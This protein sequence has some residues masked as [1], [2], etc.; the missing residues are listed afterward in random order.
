MR[1]KLKATILSLTLLTFSFILSGCV[2]EPEITP[3]YRLSSVIRVVNVSNNLNNIRVTIADQTPV[4]SLNAMPIG[5]STEYFDILS[6]KKIFR[7]YDESGQMLFSREIELASLELMTIIFA[8]HY[9]QNADLTTFT[10]FEL[11]EG[12][13]YVS[14]A[15]EAGTALFNFVHA[16]APVDSFNSRKYRV[17]ANYTPDGATARDTTYNLPPRDFLE[18]GQT[19]T[20]VATPAVYSFR[21]IPENGT[22]VTYNPVEIKENHLYYMFIYGNPNNVQVFVDEVVPPPIRPRD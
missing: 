2:E 19:L 7:V 15:P 5:S 4:Q 9:E 17:A 20:A 1:L 3:A 22:P 18:Y 10:A 16:S 14:H 12:E 21:L 11:S 13:T 8:G 6:G